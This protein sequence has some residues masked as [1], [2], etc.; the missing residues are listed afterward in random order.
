MIQ[1]EG[2]NFKEIAKF[3][4]RAVQYLAETLDALTDYVNDPK[5][6]K[7]AFLVYKIM[8]SIQK[9]T[10]QQSNYWEILKVTNNESRWDAI[11]QN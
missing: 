6:M 3:V 4:R 2:Y 5:F 9:D 10:N 8:S 1:T 11:Y 7:I